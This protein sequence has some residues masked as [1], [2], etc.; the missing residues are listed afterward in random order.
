MMDTFLSV[1]R[2]ESDPATPGPVSC[3]EL[4]SPQAESSAFWRMRRRL[5][6]T[7]LQ[8]T[9]LRARLRL[10]LVVLLSGGLWLALFWLFAQSFN[11]LEDAIPG[12]DLYDQTVRAVFGMFFMSLSVMLVFSSAIILYSSLFRAPDIA[13]LLTTPSRVERVFLHKFQEAVLLSSWAFILL[14]SPML[15]AYGMVGSAPWYY[16]ATLIPYLVAFTYLPAGLGAIACLLIVRYLPNGRLLVLILFSVV[17]IAM[18]IAIGWSLTARAESDLLT[19]TWFQEMLNRLMITEHRLLPSWWLSSGLLSASDGEWEDTVL[20]L[21]LMTSNALFLRLVSTLL[22]ARIYR[23]AYSRLQSSESSRRRTK[24]SWIDAS[25]NRLTAALPLPMRILI[26]KDVRLFRRDPVQWS[27][28]MIFFGLLILYFVNIRRFQYDT[29]YVGWVSM[30]SFLNVSVVG[31]LLSTF[32][33]RFIFPMIS[34]EGR[35]FWVLGLVAVRRETILW[36][37]F[38]FALGS[39]IIPCSVLVFLS[40]LMLR[41]EPMI[42]A[43]HQLT[44]LILCLGLSGIAVGLGARMPNLREESPSRIASGFGGTLTLVLSTLYILVIVLLTALPTH[45]YLGAQSTNAAGLL[46][47]HVRL[48][49]WIAFWLVAGTFASVVLGAIATIVPLRIGFRAFRNMEF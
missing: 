45:F 16:F 19:A 33:T 31:L 36:S 18:A 42:M 40:D 2:L 26:L 22:A 8:Q 5:F 20:F 13:F 47:A 1:P 27:Q 37:K 44:C 10:T 34:L 32:T 29:Y 38:L 23:P 28:F 7:V 12:P 4:I 35:R 49:T 39:S 6:A 25:V 43:S 41:V 3:G 15:L 21:V 30:I 11:F 24:T 46:V 48:E 17:V 14:G 9:L